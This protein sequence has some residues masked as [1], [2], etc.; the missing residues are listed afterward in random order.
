MGLFKRKSFW[1]SGREDKF[2]NTIKK[3]NEKQK[4]LFEDEE[5]EDDYDNVYEE[6]SFG[7]KIN[8]DLEDEPKKKGL[9]LPGDQPQIKNKST[10]FSRSWDKYESSGKW[11][12]YSYYKTPQLSYRFVQQM[13]NI[14]SSQYDI[15][16]EVGSSWTTDLKARKLIYN[17]ST[18]M[19]GTKGELFA[20]LLHEVGKL[21]HSK[22]MDELKSKW[23]TEYKERGYEASTIFEDVRVDMKMLKSYP[24]AAE[25]YESQE[26]LIKEVIKGY[27]EQGIAIRDFFTYNTEGLYAQIQNWYAHARRDWETKNKGSF[28][29][30]M[31]NSAYKSQLNSWTRDKLGGEYNTYEDVENTI[32]EMIRLSKEMP[33]L[34]DYLAE[35]NAFAYGVIDYVPPKVDTSKYV[36]STHEYVQKA[37]VMKSNQ[38]VID[39]MSKEVYPYIE[40]LL[41][42]SSG[43]NPS[44]PQS[45]NNYFKSN[46]DNIINGN[47]SNLGKKVGVKKGGQSH[48]RAPG[49]EYVPNSWAQ[50]DYQ[51]LKESVEA[52]IRTLVNRLTFLRREEQVVKYEPHQR[53]GK[54]DTKRLYKSRLGSRRLFKK[55]LPSTDTVRSFAFSILVDTSG[56]MQGNRMIH[57]TRALIMF[58]EVFDKMGIP[59]EIIT[60]EDRATTVKGFN[61]R[62]DKPMKAK[63][64]G[65]ANRSGGGTSLHEGIDKSTIATREES[66]KIMMVLTDGDVGNISGYNTKYFAPMDK[67]GIKSLGIGIE[68]GNYMKELCNGNSISVDNAAK[69][70]IEFVGILKGLIKRK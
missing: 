11:K 36:E 27:V 15:T 14:I 3:H 16:V 12:G 62:Y 47:T 38:E 37:G 34:E 10:S 58:S 46:R 6:Y 39:G 55:K 17:P 49:T 53:R 2:S 31:F 23:I 4:R 18:L 25:V 21:K 35:M 70:P 40:E 13:A 41:M 57:T 26:T 33:L 50:G 43:Q 7:R 64:A 51:A 24:S 20:V 60:F 19:F 54:L 8:V 56:S 69:I 45:L 61:A 42:S 48:N 59:Y 22:P 52:D 5:L 32:K 67:K 44:M 9:Q 1:D 29:R 66:N 63:I 68:T 30:D 65:L 28:D